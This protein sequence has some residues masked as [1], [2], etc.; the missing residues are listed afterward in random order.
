MCFN[1]HLG[2]IFIQLVRYTEMTVM[3]A[4]CG[5]ESPE[6]GGWQPPTQ[7]HREAPGF[8]G[9]RWRHQQEPLLQFH[10]H[11]QGRVS[12]W[13]GCRRAGVNAFFSLGP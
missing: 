2:F 13:A 10:G 3:K 7:G 4:D 1:I 8:A 11:A 9:G 6:T 5:L 12:R